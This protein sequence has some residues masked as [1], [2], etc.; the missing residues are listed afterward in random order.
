MEK[1]KDVQPEKPAYAQKRDNK[2]KPSPTTGKIKR[3]RVNRVKKS[4]ND[5]PGMCG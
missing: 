1:Q 3:H 2:F 5:K 4:H